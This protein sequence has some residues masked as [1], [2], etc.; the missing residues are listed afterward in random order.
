M[1]VY[2]NWFCNCAGLPMELIYND[3]GDEETGD[4]VCPQCGAT[5]S[6]DPK[7]TISFRDQED[8]E[9]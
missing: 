2:R 9:D 6:A 1:G 4:P 5:P 7:H 8:W 3:P